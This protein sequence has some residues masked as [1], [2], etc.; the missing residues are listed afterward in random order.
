MILPRTIADVALRMLPLLLA[1]CAWASAARAGEAAPARPSERDTAARV[2]AALRRAV[3]AAAL[4]PA[5]DDETFLRRVCLDLTGRLPTAE[6]MRRFL[7]DTAS[8]RRSRAIDRLLSS[9]A[10]AVNWGR[11]W[12]DAVTFHTPASGNY[13]RWQLFDR[14]WVEQ[15]RRNRPWN[16]VVAALVTASGVNDELAPVNY[17]TALYGNPVEIAATTSRVFLGVQIQCAQCH[18]AKTE[19]WK[20]EQFHAFAA[21]FGRARLVQHKDVSGRGTPYAI[22]SR[23]DGQ[24][25]MTDKKDPD[26]L[27]EMRPRFLTGQGVS[28]EADDQERRQALARLLT[29]PDNPWFARCFVNRVWTAL[30][31]WGFYATVADLG[32]GDKPRYPEALEALEKAWIASGYD[33]RWLFRTVARTE[34]YQRSWRPAAAA[35]G[36]A[37]A[38]C[39]CRLRPEQVFEALQQALGFDENDKSIPAPAPRSAPAVQRHTG[40]RNMVYQAFKTDPSLP[41]EEVQGT[42]PQALV[43][44]NSQLVNTWIAAKGQTF[45]AEALKKETSDDEIVTLLYERTLGR[46]PRAEE[47]AVCRRYIRKVGNRTEA[48]E[49]VFWSLVNSTEFLTKR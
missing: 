48:L 15:F 6:D 9:E 32:G 10:Y 1:A 37:P 39:P 12:R 13:L 45:L 30:F 36:G 27:I 21:F 4:P 47:L 22:E 38:V 35:A 31:G 2:D 11:Y 33:V 46:Q 8:D 20:R 3:P 7:A 23:A 49:D 24:Y 44:M 40:V 25:C 17:L 5:A 19:P 16:E 28:L 26:H 14:W 43:M 18:D 34:A 29:A 41:R 42:I